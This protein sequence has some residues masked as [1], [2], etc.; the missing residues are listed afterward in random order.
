MTTAERVRLEGLR[1]LAEE[2]LRDR[3]EVEFLGM[4]MDSLGME[5][6]VHHHRHRHHHPVDLDQL[7]EAKMTE[8]RREIKAKVQDPGRHRLRFG[9]MEEKTVIKNQLCQVIQLVQQ[10]LGQQKQE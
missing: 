2:D 8:A 10:K 5:G 3:V 9:E 6:H 4:V 1:D 7:V